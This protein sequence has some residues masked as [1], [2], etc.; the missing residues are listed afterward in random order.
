MEHGVHGRRYT[1]S[2]IR[3]ET[4][5]SQEY[6]VEMYEHTT[7]EESEALRFRTTQA[8][9]D[10][11]ERLRAMLGLRSTSALLRRLLA[12]EGSRRGVSEQ[13]KAVSCVRG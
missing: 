1:L 13:P 11:A 8:E 9:R 6:S 2:V 7:K 3:A 12:E 10:L 5:Q 4:S